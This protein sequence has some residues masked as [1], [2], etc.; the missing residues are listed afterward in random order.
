MERG[1]GF[2][3]VFG[4][5]GGEDGSPVVTPGGRA[6]VADEQAEDVGDGDVAGRQVGVVEFFAPDYR[7]VSDVQVLGGRGST[8]HRRIPTLRVWS[9]PI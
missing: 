5:E 6:E 8:R 1:C 2:E 3:E 4:L 9:S 7:A